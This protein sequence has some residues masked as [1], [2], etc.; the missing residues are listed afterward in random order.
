MERRLA[1][2][3]EWM[4]SWTA[5]VVSPRCRR[6]VRRRVCLSARA[7]GAG[8]VSRRRWTRHFWRRW[9]RHF[10]GAGHGTSLE[11]CMAHV[12]GADCPHVV[13]HP[14]PPLEQLAL[15]CWPLGFR[16]RCGAAVDAPLAALA[17]T[18]RFPAAAPS[19]CHTAISMLTP[20]LHFVAACRIQSNWSKAA[21]PALPRH[22][23]L[24]RLADTVADAA[25]PV[26]CSRA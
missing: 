9:P 24:Q 8:G 1:S 3:R 17:A 4:L 5:A 14:V 21:R 11:T 16:P 22:L 7:H 19:G 6:P 20:Q 12:H 15:S 2:F 26:F 10:E 18:T 13:R 25:T 23:L